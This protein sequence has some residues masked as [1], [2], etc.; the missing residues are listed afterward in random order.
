MKTL[1]L[2]CSLSMLTLGS[3][4]SLPPPP[5]SSDNNYTASTHVVVDA[6]DNVL[7][8]YGIPMDLAISDLKDLPHPVKMGQEMEEGDSYTVAWIKA[9]RGV[10]I[11]VVFDDDGANGKLYSAVTVSPTAIG[12]RRIAVGSSLADV[13]S[14]WPSGEL[15]YGLAHGE[16]VTFKTGTNV[17]YQFNPGEMPKQAFDD[18]FTKIQVPNLRVQSIRLMAP[19]SLIERVPRK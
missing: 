11:K 8:F 4:A 10:E 9:E 13:K 7:R 17:Y 14:A 19:G 6:K 5:T 1:H 3:C 12:P 15:I 16:Y 18:D 2:A